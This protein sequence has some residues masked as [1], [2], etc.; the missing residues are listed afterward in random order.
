[1]AS[2][3]RMVV[4]FVADTTNMKANMAAL[5]GDLARFQTNA[6]R[7]A[8]YATGGF[9]DMGNAMQNIGGAMQK[10]GAS[11]TQ[12]VSLPLIGLGILASK[13]GVDFETAF[14]GVRKTI[15]EDTTTSF[16]Y[17]KEA[18]L[19][20][21]RDTGVAATEVAAIM[22]VAGQLGI[23]GNEGL[24]KFTEQIAKLSITTGIST[25]SLA[26]MMGKFISISGLTA[27]ADVERISNVITALGNSTAT[28]E[29]AIM[30]F[31]VRIAAVG[32]LSGISAEDVLALSAA[33]EASGTKAE[34]GGTAF[35]KIFL[36]MQSE[37]LGAK[38]AV[39][40][41]GK[42]IDK[43]SAEIQR[44]EQ[45]LA[46]ARAEQE[47]LGSSATTEQIQRLSTEIQTATENITLYKEQNA[48][49]AD[50][51]ANAS[52]EAS[53]FA[54]LLGVSATEFKAMYQ[55]EDGAINIFEK[56]IA[57]IN[58]AQASG[59]DLTAVM[60]GLGLKD[61]R[62]VQ[63]VLSLAKAN[64]EGTL[65]L[66]SF[67]EAMKTADAAAENMSD[68]Q[69][70][71][72]KRLDTV[73]GQWSRLVEILKSFAVFFTDESNGVIKEYLRSFND[74]LEKILTRLKEMDPAQIKQ[75]LDM[76]IGL[77]AL[78]PALSIFGGILKGVGGAMTGLSGIA[79]LI[80][81]GMGK[82]IPQGIKNALS[83]KELMEEGLRVQTTWGHKLGKTLANSFDIGFTN[84]GLTAFGDRFG[85]RIDG[86]LE[87]TKAKIA[88]S[89][90]TTTTTQIW[91]YDVEGEQ[92]GRTPSGQFG[93]KVG[94]DIVSKV[95][96][97]ETTT[98]DNFFSKQA[99]KMVDMLKGMIGLIPNFMGLLAGLAGVL[100][101][102]A[103][104][105]TAFF[106]ATGASVQ[107]V[108]NLFLGF[109]LAIGKFIETAGAFLASLITKFPE[110]AKKFG[111]IFAVVVPQLG[112]LA[113]QLIEGFFTL[114]P[115]I[116]TLGGMFIV[117]LIEG[118]VANLPELLAQAVAMVM[119][120][121]RGFIDNLP[122]IITVAMDI[123]GSLIYGLVQAL[124]M[125]LSAAI[126]LLTS[127]IGLFMDKIQDGTFI[128]IG[129]AIIQGLLDGLASLGKAV[130]ETMLEI[131]KSLW[132]GIK[133]FFGIKS[134]SKKMFE[135]GEFI[136]EGLMNGIK[137]YFEL[138]KL[139]WITIP[140][141]LLDKFIGA[142]T[143]LYNIGKDILTG[144]WNGI[145][146][147]YTTLF[148]TY[149]NV[150]KWILDAFI[151]SGTWLFE[152]GKNIMQGLKNGIFE[153]GGQMG[154]WVSEL[155]SNFVNG[156]KNFFGV[157]SPSRVMMKIGNYIGEGL[158]IGIDDSTSDILASARAMEEA[159]MIDP[160]IL[161]GD[162]NIDGTIK[163]NYDGL[164]E[165]FIQAL[166]M[167]G[168]NVYLDG[169]E[170]TDKIQKR[171][172]L[173]QR[174]G[175]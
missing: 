110:F 25:D 103:V 171:L 114:L 99:P 66:S 3:S 50:E 97:T 116:L 150:G 87:G 95:I 121:A 45:V 115:Q 80:S 128:K 54:K 94:G 169:D 104:G 130:W 74:G 16:A 154:R 2:L 6:Q 102:V 170:V 41:A 163:H 68:T 43:N 120:F 168:L 55:A 109:E 22:Q 175:R 89:L 48:A 164:T 31:G 107:D 11:M 75:M 51:M 106:V 76:F 113:V 123:I 135:I 18:I 172:V 124:P 105:F 14:A 29:D 10:M 69:N 20:I 56:F 86:V 8:M 13:V 12:Y 100:A 27:E 174:R 73:S 152:V 52:D 131:L 9:A 125:L 62:L 108:K 159:A 61:T 53:G 24:E 156:V 127:L 71:V 90:K 77:I 4:Q 30:K 46:S 42:E 151:G 136:M 141:F 72:N 21:A 98:K 138:L 79:G 83:S 15:D 1:M 117:S 166:E 149:F 101:L 33:A 147:Y 165:A 40:S 153:I 65:T 57:K 26:M 112:E 7:N 28:T 126:G 19:G 84:Q 173:A 146:W 36:K 167:V 59:Q 47:Q 93:N 145:E 132:N 78:G 60:D 137:A 91:G 32:R 133:E 35:T 92:Q 162:R 58:E 17:L 134:P 39:S 143:W 67:T 160:A 118:L 139:F 38:E 64:E 157:K 140:K 34:R 122:T 37:A 70:E 81:V 23:R 49:L 5:E 63:A 142:L 148:K 96:G 119:A 111:E 82:E 155:G 44:W 144:L 158:A 85:K 129:I 161:S 88:N